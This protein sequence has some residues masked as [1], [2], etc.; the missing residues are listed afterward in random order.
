MG[1]IFDGEVNDVASLYRGG[2]K[3]TLLLALGIVAIIA[4]LLLTSQATVGVAV[5]GTG[6]FLAICARIDQAQSQHETLMKSLSRQERS[7]GTGQP[8]STQPEEE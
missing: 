8:A 7:S 2:K 1:I 4:G 3:V 6:C 5:I